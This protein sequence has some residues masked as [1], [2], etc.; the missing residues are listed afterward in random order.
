MPTTYA[1]YIFG[2]EVL[3]LLDNDIKESINKNIDL[4]NIGLHGPDI[5]FYYNPLKSNEISKL[6]HTLHSQT[7][8]RFFENARKVI[9]R[10]D[11]YDAACA[12]ISG[13]ICHFILDTQCHPYIRQK[14]SNVLTHGD[15]ETEFDRMFMLK[16]KLNPLSFKPTTHIVPNEENAEIISWFFDGITKDAILKA[17]QSMKFYLNLLVAPGH[18]KRFVILTSLKLTGNYKGMSGLIMKYEPLRKSNETNMNL[19]D[20]FLEGINSAADIIKEFIKNIKSNDKLNERFNRNF[21]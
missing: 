8:D 6:G 1:H 19:Y 2:Q 4:Y 5:L 17:L 9:S 10:S 18:F 11:D 14:E 15:I 7:A 13:F 20:L 3:K 12:Y 16:N 21:E